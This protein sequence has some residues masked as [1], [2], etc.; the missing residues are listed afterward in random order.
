[1]NTIRDNSQRAHNAITLLWIVMSIEIISAIS[2]GM[3]LNLLQNIVNG[4][5]VSDKAAN[6]N[7]LREQII[8]IVFLVIYIT[9][10]TVFIQWF[11][12]AYFNLHRNISYLK[13]DEG[14]AAGSWLVPFVNLYRPYQIMKELYVETK[15]LLEKIGGNSA[16]NLPTQMLALWWTIWLFNG[17]FG[18]LV[19]RFSMKAE[20]LD[21]YI[22]LTY[23]NLIS[24]IIDIGLAYITIRIVRN[25]SIAEDELHMSLFENARQGHYSE[26]NSSMG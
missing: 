18:Q 8:G 7:D 1:M 23:G 6:N 25:L 24:S 2:S 13:Y 26:L 4:V 9:S 3:Q 10:G 22:L 19:F 21:D 14:W 11:R 15:L 17:F 5:Q 20:S 12:R 16:H